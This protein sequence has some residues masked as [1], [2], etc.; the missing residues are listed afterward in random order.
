MKRYYLLV[1]VVLSLF[2]FSLL[3]SQN[4]IWH[5]SENGTG[6]GSSWTLSSN[7]LQAVI[8]NAQPGDQVWIKQGSYQRTAGLSF[9]V[10]DSVSV[11]GGFPNVANPTQNDRN[12]RLYE[13]IL[14]GN[15]ARVLQAYGGVYPISP[16]TIIDG[17]T[18]RDGYDTAGAGLHIST[19]DATFRNLKIINN[20][21][22]MGM[23]A[24][25]NIS[26][27]NSTFIQVLVANNTSLLTPGSDG[28]T[29]GIRI[30]GGGGTKFYNCVVANN[31][32]NGYVGG[33]W[34]AN[35]SCYFYNSIIYGNTANLHSEFDTGDNYRALNGVDFYASNC[36]LQGCRGSDYFYEAPQYAIYGADLGGNFD[37]NPMFNPDY[38]LQS[39][40]GINKG[41]TLAYQS[42]AN[43]T[44][45]DFFN[46]NRI[47]DAIDIGLS[48]HQNV[49]SEILYV[50]QNA[51]G[52]GSSWADAS[53]N[54]QQ[55]MDKQFKGKSVWVAEG[56]YYAPEIYFKL[57]D[58]IKVYGGFPAV[59]NP[60]FADRNVALHPTVLTSTH[61]MIIGNFYPADKKISAATLLDGFV[62]TKNENSPE[63]MYGLFES[64]SE[65]TYSNITF[66]G[67]DYGAVEIRRASA[68]SF[69]DCTFKGNHS[70]DDFHSTILLFDGSYAS[71]R[72][73]NFTEN[74]GFLGSGMRAM[75]NSNVLIDDCLFKD[76]NKDRPSGIGKVI[77]I[78]HS[79]ATITNSVFDSNGY[80]AFD[81]GIVLAFGVHDEENPGQT[82]P[83]TVN[84]DRCVFKNNLNTALDVNGK[85][86]DQISISNSLFYKNVS[87][88]GA[89]LRKGRLGDVYITNCTFTENHASSQWGGGLFFSE[90]G[91]NNSIR[92][93]IIWNNSSVYPYAPEMWMFQNVSFKNSIIR[94]SGGSANWQAG[95]FNNFD[96]APLSTNLGGNLDVNPMF[97]DAA[98]EDY[99]LLSASPAI[100]VGDN[101]W[102]NSGATPDLSAFLHDLNGNDRILGSSVD[103]GAFEFDPNLSAVAFA[104]SDGL[105]IYPNPAQDM[106]HIRWADA[107]VKDVRVY[108]ALG[109]ELITSQNETVDFSG[110]SNG[111]Y[112]VKVVSDGGKTQAAKLIK[113]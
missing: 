76:N 112:F 75:H 30:G 1:A 65:V 59:G 97:A 41:N 8:D 21:S 52:N 102:Y 81:G 87:S 103:L 95:A 51:T 20:T 5:V 109:K 18:I 68:N 61:A 10:K 44:G 17:L 2:K 64:N 55:M 70:A 11:Y 85:A 86:T 42:A 74:Y 92:N 45:K 37:T 71:F 62:V 69:I 67:L 79:K 83:V 108:S 35:T 24:G 48:E 31:H 88:V 23:G 98:T 43:N 90:G 50:R 25:M 101:S 106:V 105:S 58:S 91:G 40:T 53:G 111:I 73:C 107:T 15:Q 84:I 12:P 93:S 4:S 38:T 14:K 100:N 3:F 7:N 36:I 94:T 33:I 46:N 28:D 57:R 60:T 39:S 32:A 26:N 110:L 34:L 56:T 22:S 78:E 54:L 6:N 66:T 96:I 9:S 63:L 72:G 80:S 104:G 89:G 27:S 113:K 77:V 47:V 99:R 19:C 13:T 49:Q 16:A 29:A 82:H